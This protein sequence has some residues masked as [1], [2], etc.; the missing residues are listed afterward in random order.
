[1]FPHY[2]ATIRKF[3]KLMPSPGYGKQPM[4]RII[5]PFLLLAATPTIAQDASATPPTAYALE[6]SATAELVA[7][8][9]HFNGAVKF[10]IDKQQ[11]LVADYIQGGSTYRTDMAY[12][13]FLDA[14]TCAYNAEQKSLVLQCQDPRSKCIE[15]EMRKPSASSSVSQMSLPLPSNDPTGEKARQLLAGFVETKQNEG[16]MRLA[17]TNTR[18]NSTK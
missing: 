10:R 5:L 4:K 2:V 9:A 8:N 12:V 1:M 18:S 3:H 11:R 13:D 15:T 6:T 17:E 7:L 14:S 16:L